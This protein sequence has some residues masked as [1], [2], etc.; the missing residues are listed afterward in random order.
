MFTF[1]PDT[2]G[3]LNADDYDLHHRPENTDA[4]IAFLSRHCA[5]GRV[6]ELAIGT[7]RI[8]VP[9]AQAGIDVE[10]IEASQKMVDLMRAKPGG[11]DIPVVIGDMT[12]VAANGPFDH[13]LLVYNT[14][15]NLP[16]QEAQ[17]RLFAAISPPPRTQCAGY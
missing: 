5:G 14:L 11:A 4:A 13:V 17:I 8:A 12:D 15:F 2:F 6:L 9:L 10:G 16:D 7:G 1:E 3:V